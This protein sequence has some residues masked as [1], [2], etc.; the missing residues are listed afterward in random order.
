MLSYEEIYHTYLNPALRQSAL[1]QFTKE[2]EK[3]HPEEVG[4]HWYVSIIGVKTTHQRRGIGAMFIRQ[5]QELARES[6]VPLTLGASK[7]GRG[8]YKKCGFEVTWEG[9]VCGIEDCTMI[10]RPS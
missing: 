10:W 8:L 9:T 5:G 3:L 1:P 7:A 4:P 2:I 6:G